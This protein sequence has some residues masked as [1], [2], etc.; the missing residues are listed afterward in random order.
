MQATRIK[1]VMVS[2]YEYATVSQEATLAEALVTLEKE[3]KKGDSSRGHSKICLVI[4][5]NYDVVG[6]TSVFEILRVLEPQQGKFQEVGI[7][8]SSISEEKSLMG[9]KKLHLWEE[10]LKSIFEKATQLQVKD[11]MYVP[12]DVERV[13][14]FATLGDV[15]HRV[16]AGY[17]HPLL[18]T[19]GGHIT[20]ILRMG[21]VFREIYN[22]NLTSD[23]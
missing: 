20:G 21:D 10:P 15:V 7:E 18:V 17:Q 16:V 12:S 13:D 14:H 6:E 8:F 2:I 11:I 9:F 4:D 19:K 22:K 23:S 1:D 5:E 3:Q